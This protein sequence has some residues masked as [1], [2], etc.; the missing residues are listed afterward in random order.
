MIKTIDN[1]EKKLDT[2]NSENTKEKYFRRLF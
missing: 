1:I 2:I